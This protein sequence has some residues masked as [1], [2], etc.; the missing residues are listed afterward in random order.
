LDLVFQ[1]NRRVYGIGDLIDPAV[2]TPEIKQLLPIEA[3]EAELANNEKNWPKKNDYVLAITGN[4]LATWQ[5]R[6][7]GPY[8]SDGS[9]LQR[10]GSY[11]MQEVAGERSYFRSAFINI[12]TFGLE[13]GQT[14]AGYELY[15]VIGGPRFT[16]LGRYPDGWMGRR[17]RLT[18]YP[19]YVANALVHVATSRYNPRN[20]VSVFQDDVLIDKA[21]LS[22]GNEHTFKL[23]PVS[24]DVPTVFRFEVERT[25]VPQKL[26]LSKDKREL[27]AF[28]RLEPFAAKGK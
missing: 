6:G 9:F 8:Y 3:S 28:V 12:W 7:V 14:Y 18:L 23:K 22:E 27:G 5:V 10:D 21:A 20:S 2:V 17:A 11:D 25:F 13:F 1:E 19:E 4:E 16:W 15:R 24:K 26:R